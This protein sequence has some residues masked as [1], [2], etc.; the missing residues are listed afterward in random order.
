MSLIE[1][2]VPERF[3]DL[4]DRLTGRLVTTADPDWDAERQAWNL[5]VDQHPEAVVVPVDASD[6]AIVVGFA[7]DNGLRVVPQST[8]HLAAPLGDLS[9]TVLLHT[10]RLGGVE[11]DPAAETV[12]VG[13]GVVW[14]EVTSALEPYGLAALAGSSPDVGVAGYLLGAGFSWMARKR[15]LGCSAVTAFDVVTADG[16]Q[17]HV[18][19]ETEP[20]L[21]WAL[22]GG[23]GTTAIVTAFTFRVFP[24]ATVY[25]GMLLF[26]LARAGKVLRAYEEW[27][28][29]L[30]EDATTCVRLLR[31]PPLPD[32]PD[33]LRGQSFVGVDGAIDLPEAEAAAV[34]EPLRA[35]EPAIDTFGVLPASQLGLVHMDPPQPVPALGDGMI[36]DDLPETAIDALLGVVGPESG[37]ALLA[38]DLRHLGGAAGRPAE[39][40][41]AVDHLPGRFVVYAVGLLADPALVPV[42]TAEVAAVRTALAPWT[43]ERDY[44]NFRE[45]AAAPGR[46][47]DDATLE[48]LRAIKQAYD[49][50]RTIRTAHDLD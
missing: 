33:F 36:I 8:G 49:P 50:E 16:R 40:G 34:L 9:G 43:S 1:T 20:D 45:V 37:S 32:L 48:R 12:R 30:T 17:R 10:S 31:I 18:T 28:R 29:D 4:A 35:L 42:L 11:V 14:G 21:F 41:G 26:P 5:A 46:F 39:G 15:G 27:T 44:S 7:R 24:V 6:I 23:G 3:R 47:W 38:V 2:A 13:A 19:A 22:R 25:A